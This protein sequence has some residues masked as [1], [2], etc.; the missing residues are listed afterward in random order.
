MVKDKTR[1]V[2]G[3]DQEGQ[4]YYAKEFGIYDIGSSEPTNN[5]EQ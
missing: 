3:P 4:E 1:R 5:F 2:A